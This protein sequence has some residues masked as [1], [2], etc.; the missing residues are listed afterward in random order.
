MNRLHPENVK[1]S[2]SIVNRTFAMWATFS[3]LLITWGF[4][5]LDER[6]FCL[7]G[8]DVGICVGN[9]KEPTAHWS[10]VLSWLLF[11]SMKSSWKV[12]HISSYPGRVGST[13]LEHKIV[14]SFHTPKWQSAKNIAPVC[15]RLRSLKS[16]LR[17]VTHSRA[18]SP[19]KFNDWTTCYARLWYIVLT[20][21]K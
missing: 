1:S 18:P 21:R 10:Y 12:R 6:F 17:E 14:I 9:L 13:R 19:S 8:S 7:E 11:W 4:F 16:V 5:V 2:L 15:G 3:G 20:I